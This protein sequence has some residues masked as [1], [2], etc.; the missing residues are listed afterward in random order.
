MDILSMIDLAIG[1]AKH[2][3]AASLHRDERARHHGRVHLAPLPHS[4]LRTQHRNVHDGHQLRSFHVNARQARF[5]EYLLLRAGLPLV[6]GL[7]DPR[8]AAA[9]DHEE[10]PAQW[11]EGRA[12]ATPIEALGDVMAALAGRDVNTGK[13]VR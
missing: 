3:Q 11:Q 6:G 8:N 5:A 7:I 4:R 2:G 12:L 1:T 9:A 13:K 10:M